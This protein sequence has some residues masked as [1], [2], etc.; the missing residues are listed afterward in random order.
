[1]KLQGRIANQP[2]ADVGKMVWI[3]NLGSKCLLDGCDL[4]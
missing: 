4:F 2:V 3:K 1:M